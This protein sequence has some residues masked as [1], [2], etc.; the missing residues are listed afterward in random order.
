ADGL[1]LTSDKGA[2]LGIQDF[3]VQDNAGV[4]LDNF[5]NFDSND[6]ITFTITT[7]GVPTTTTDIS[8]NMSGVNDAA[9]QDEMSEAFY[10]ALSGALDEDTFSVEL[11]SAN[12]AVLIR[13]L[14]GSNI[15][16]ENGDGDT[17]DDATI[18]L[19]ALNGTTTSGVGNTSFEFV[20]AANDQETFNADTDDTDSIGFSV[21]SLTTTSMAGTT[22]YVTESSFTGAGATTAA[23][24]MSTVTVL[25]DDGISMVSDSKTSLGLFGSAGSATTGSS[26]ITLGGEGGF[27]SFTAGETISFDVDGTAV[28]YTVSTDAGGTTESALANQLYTELDAVLAATDYSLI[29]NGKSVSIIKTTSSEAP[30]EIT[31]FTESGSNDAILAVNTGAGEGTNDPVNGL[32]DAGSTYRNFTTSTL[33]DDEATIYWEKLDSE[34]LHTGEYGTVTVEDEGTVNIVEDGAA[35]LSFNIGAGELVAGN[36]LS[37]NTDEN[38]EP[39]PLDFTISKQANSV[40]DIYTFTVTTGGTVGHLDDNGESTLT[41]QWQNSVS[42]GS[43]VI[44]GNDPPYTPEAAVSV[45]V[46][47]MTL[48]FY[49]G[50]LIDGDVFTITTNESGTPTA[51]NED[52]LATGETM[53]DWHWTLDSF[54]EQFNRQAGG[55]TA[56]VN[57][58][59]PPST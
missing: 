32:L 5:T 57:T 13:T 15:T 27:G 37:I 41:I 59:S 43:F 34:G 26:I 24:I 2:T 21:T 10:S 54:T 17:G 14:D 1:I 58:V 49:D 19:T 16:M 39:D 20:A 38:G 56:T 36:T 18:N 6:T 55:I 33:Y 50:T 28:N 53:S 8:I 31:N 40:N 45:S 35:S 23:A 25:M 52:G 11:D 51:T 46:D 29:Q 3:E 47:G 7:D 22:A 4:Q 9:N 44:E 30:I 42:S 12:D 48:N